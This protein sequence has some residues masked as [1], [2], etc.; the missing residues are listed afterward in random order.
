MNVTSAVT[1]KIEIALIINIADTLK[2]VPSD[3][4]KLMLNSSITPLVIVGGR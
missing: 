3:E 2:A 1:E 4:I